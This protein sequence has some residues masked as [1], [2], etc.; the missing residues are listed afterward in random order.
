MENVTESVCPENVKAC[1]SWD[2]WNNP[3]RKVSKSLSNEHTLPQNACH[4][5]HTP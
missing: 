3:E 4:V 5:S 2:S 1:A